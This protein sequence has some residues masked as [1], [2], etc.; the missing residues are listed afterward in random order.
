MATK[1]GKLL[2]LLIKSGRIAAKRLRNIYD[3]LNI[4]II[5]KNNAS[6]KSRIKSLPM[7]ILSLRSKLVPVLT[8]RSLKLLLKIGRLISVSEEERN[9]F[10][11]NLNKIHLMGF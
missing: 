9:L 4:N 2:H 1:N 6:V 8:L 7:S 11:Q 10:L 3:T 5:G